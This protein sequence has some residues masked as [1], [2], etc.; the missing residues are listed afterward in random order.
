MRKNTERARTI[1]HAGGWPRI[2][3]VGEDG[4]DAMW[5][6]VQ[7]SVLE[8]EFMAACIPILEP[9]VHQGEANG[10]QLAFLQ[11]RVQLTRHQ[12]R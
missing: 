3:D 5:L 10:W 2:S 4:S 12:Y 6:I 7:H 1:L 8:P 9:L 11:D